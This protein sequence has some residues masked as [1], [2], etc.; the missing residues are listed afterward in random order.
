[1]CVLQ[2]ICRNESSSKSET[3]G[4]AEDEDKDTGIVNFFSANYDK[5]LER[6]LCMFCVYI[7]LAS[8]IKVGYH[9]SSFLTNNIPES[10]VLIMTGLG[11]G[12]FFK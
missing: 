1:M 8:L 10:C 5:A 3:E 12:T 9:Q 7:I 6:T 2:V 11:F 4:A